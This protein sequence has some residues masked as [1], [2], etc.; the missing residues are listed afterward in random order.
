M[1]GLSLVL[2]SVKTLFN[3][4]IP[5][6]VFESLMIS[7]MVG[8]GP[9]YPLSNVPTREE[10]DEEEITMPKV[11]KILGMYIIVPILSL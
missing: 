2:F 11:L 9:L 3:I 4:N 6:D 5:E 10:M 8:F 7:C 1:G